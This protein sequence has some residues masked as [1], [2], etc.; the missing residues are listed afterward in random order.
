MLGTGYISERNGGISADWDKFARDHDQA[1]TDLTEQEQKAVRY[2]EEQP[3]KKQV[4]DE[5]GV[6]TVKEAPP[7]NN[8]PLSRLLILVRRVRNNLFH[9]EKFNALLEGD[10]KRDTELLDH[11]LTILYACLKR[12]TEISDKFY[13]ETKWELDNGQEEETEDE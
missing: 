5:D 12:S 4:V 10:S 3:P 13:S 7:Q 6:L 9:G 11:E 1:F 8:K 2:Y